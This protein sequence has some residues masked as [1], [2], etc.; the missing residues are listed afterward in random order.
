VPSSVTAAAGPWWA[1]KKTDRGGA[2]ARQ[3]ELPSRAHGPEGE[4]PPDGRGLGKRTRWILGQRVV[5]WRGMSMGRGYSESIPAHAMTSRHTNVTETNFFLYCTIEAR[6]HPHVRKCTCKP[7]KNSMHPHV[8]M[9]QRQRA[10]F[11]KQK[12]V[13]L[14]MAQT[15][16]QACSSAVPL[17]NLW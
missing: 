7:T 9:Y 16:M 15:C 6:M 1:N 13:A 10:F 12:Q 11:R 4:S 8:R 2:A 14:N 5:R 3:S 17:F